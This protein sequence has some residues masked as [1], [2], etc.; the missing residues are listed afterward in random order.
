MSIRPDHPLPHYLLQQWQNSFL[1]SGITIQPSQA[2]IMILPPCRG[3]APIWEIPKSRF[4]GLQAP[5][6]CLGLKAVISALHHWVSV[7]EGWKVFITRY[8]IAVFSYT[9]KQGVTLSL[10]LFCLAV[11]IFMWLEAQN[12]VLRVR[13]IPAVFYCVSRPL[14]ADHLSRP[15]SVSI[16][17]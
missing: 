8:N 14:L 13:Y 1:A 12:M 4:S 6:H 10:S 7:I 2:D 9:N 17:T 11:D 16:Q 15:T 5:Y 3:T